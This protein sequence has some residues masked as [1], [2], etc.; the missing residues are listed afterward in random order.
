MVDV[1]S[2]V[3]EPA[4]GGR[5][6]TRYEWDEHTRW[7]RDALKKLEDAHDAACQRID[8]LERRWDRYAGPIVLLLA[9]MGLI[10]TTASIASAV[11]IMGRTG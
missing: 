4:N 2:P 11:V 5:Y 7:S 8:Q 6:V 3:R 1:P 9:V 10:A